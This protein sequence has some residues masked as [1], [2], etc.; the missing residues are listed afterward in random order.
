[1]SVFERDRGL[2]KLRKVLEIVD[3]DAFLRMLWAVDALASG[4]SE[5]AKPFF[6]FPP[7]AATSDPASPYRVHRWE[8]ETLVNQFLLV[9]RRVM[10][11]GVNRVRMCQNYST[12]TDLVNSIRQVENAQAGL[13]LKSHDVFKE[14]HRIA[15]RQFHWQRGY[16]NTPH[17]YR[18]I[19]I[20]GHGACAEYFFEKNGFTI[21]DFALV[22]FSVFAALQQHSAVTRDF[23]VPKITPAPEITAN[24]LRKMSTSVSQGNEVLKGNIVATKSSRL[25]ISYQPALIR[26]FPLV[27]TD[28]PGNVLIGPLPEAV[29]L[30]VTGG[31][32]YD[33]VG[34]PSGLRNVIGDRFEAYSHNLIGDLLPNFRT[35]RSSRYS[36]G[37]AGRAVDT[38]DLRVFD[39]ETVSVVVECKATKLSFGAQYDLNPEVV[40]ADAYREIGKGVFQIWRYFSHCRAGR[41]NDR[42]SDATVGLVLTLDPWL[43]MARELHAHV[44]GIASELADKEGEILECDRRQVRFCSIDDFE[45]LLSK[46]DEGE[47]VQ[48]LINAG[49]EQYFGWVLPSVR[50]R[51]PAEARKKR[52]PYKLDQLLPWW[53]SIRSLRPV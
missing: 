19:F 42:V 2:K 23:G 49:E 26:Q 47:F 39:G 18:S 8:A 38:P 1:M 44:M 36:K 33:L 22:G 28:V 5:Y 30:R 25:P 12:V 46:S 31:L 21:Q 14:L 16:F 35:E 20:F 24:C 27:H 53:K 15:Q 32:Y 37:G 17:F 43:I 50:D 13:N 51:L 45:S 40:A 10:R 9:E 48:T 6:S 4:R 52:Y 11:P 29:L 7:E 41:L 34:G 3:E